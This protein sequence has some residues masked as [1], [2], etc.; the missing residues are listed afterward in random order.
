[1]VKFCSC[2]ERAARSNRRCPRRKAAVKRSA[3]L[4]TELRGPE[5]FRVAPGAPVVGLRTGD[6]SSRRRPGLGKLL[7]LHRIATYAAA[8]PQ[9]E[10]FAFCTETRT[11]TT[12]AEIRA[13]RESQGF[14]SVARPAQDGRLPASTHDNDLAV[15][16]QRRAERLAKAARDATRPLTWI[17]PSR[18]TSA[19]CG[20]APSSSFRAPVARQCAPLLS[21]L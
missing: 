10:H 5:R 18:I 4:S 3:A 2:A 11:A 13:Q 21:G 17:E 15:G 20:G 1:M 8:L 6:P 9:A 16:L 12:T 7:N 19:R 14:D